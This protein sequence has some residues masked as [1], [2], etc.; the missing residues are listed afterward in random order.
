[1]LTPQL[2]NCLRTFL[3]CFFDIPHFDTVC[4]QLGRVKL[5]NNTPMIRKKSFLVGLLNIIEFPE[6]IIILVCFGI[7]M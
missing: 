5:I 2:L 6:K 1:M 7:S 4:V 3:L